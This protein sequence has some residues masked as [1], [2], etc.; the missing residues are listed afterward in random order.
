M[1]T[2]VLRGNKVSDTYLRER[3]PLQMQSENPGGSAVPCVSGQEYNSISVGFQS[4]SI[5]IE[6]N[7]S[8][9]R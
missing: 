3:R 6:I 9:A 8:S 4:E 2:A 1:I 5:E 7:Y